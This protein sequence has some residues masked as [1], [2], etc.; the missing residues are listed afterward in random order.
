M[1]FLS[2]S[3][4]ATSRALRTS[5]CL[6]NVI[7]KVFY[8]QTQVNAVLFAIYCVGRF[9]RSITCICSKYYIR[10]HVRIHIATHNDVMSGWVVYLNSL[11]VI[12]IIS[13]RNDN[14]VQVLKNVT[15]TLDV[16]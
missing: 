4:N 14:F 9:I 3:L 15:A 11:D 16:I 8:S 6:S 2:N 13:W 10:G 1:A 5:A 7:R 12:P